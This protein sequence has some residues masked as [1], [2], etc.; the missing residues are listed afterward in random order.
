MET[1][2]LKE[3]LQSIY[4]TR[5][6][7]T[8]CCRQCSCCRV[9]CP[10]MKYSE[11]LSIV[12]T[13]WTAWAREA[14][15]AFL[16][17]CVRYFF[18]KSLI[19]PCPMLVGKDCLIYDDRPLNCRLYGLWPEDVYEKRVASLSK[20]IGLD[21]EKIPLNT[22][23]PY[24]ELKP[25]PCP[26]CNGTGRVDGD[27]PC[28]DCL[29]DGVTKKA[30]LTSEKIDKMFSALDKLDRDVAGVPDEKIASYWNYRTLHDWVL[31][32]FF[33]EQW[34]MAMTHYAMSSSAENIKAFLDVLEKEIDGKIENM[35]PAALPEAEPPK[36]E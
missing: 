18:S 15:V 3:K 36:H 17:T 6:L 2:T 4:A 19:K 34:L 26:V 32:I 10:Q 11:A 22:Q 1:K 27:Q 9:A 20:I 31:F 35:N 7:S 29:G 13:V 33:G 30:H 23:C 5:N 14:K 25:L 12:N 28:P 16:M 21:K 8:V 24:V